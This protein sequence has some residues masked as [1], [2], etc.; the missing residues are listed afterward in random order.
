MITLPKANPCPDRPRGQWFRYPR[1]QGAALI[2][3]LGILALLI[4]LVVSY[5]SLATTESRS[6]RGYADGQTVKRLADSAT[7]IVMSQLREATEGFSKDGAGNLDPSSPL[8]WATQ[9]GMAHT[10]HSSGSPDRAFKL[11]SSDEMIVDRASATPL[12]EASTMANWENQ[13]GVFTD[14]NSPVMVPG[15]GGNFTPQSPI[16]DVDGLVDGASLNPPV[17]GFTYA[18][19]GVT[20]DIEGF[21]IIPPASY[22]PGEPISPINNPAPM[23]VR[24]LYVL[25][26]GQLTAPRHDSGEGTA[27]FDL[28]GQVSPTAENPIVARI[29]FW[30]DDECAKVNVNTAS[31]GTYWDIPRIWS[32]E[33]IGDYVGDDVLRTPGLSF[34]QPAQKE[35]QRYAG[36]PATTSL[37]PVLGRILPRPATINSS[38]A[39]QFEDYY[40]LT[41]RTNVGG[42]RSGTQIVRSPIPIKSDRLFPSVSDFL[43][44]PTHSTGER[45]IN[46]ALNADLV[47]RAGF[48]LSAHSKAPET[49]LFNT[50]RIAIWPVW[51]DATKRTAYD[52]L[53]AFCSTVGGQPFHF[54]RSDSRSGTAGLTQRNKDLYTWIFNQTANEIPGYGGNFAAKLGE[55]RQ[56]VLTYI[57]DYIRSTNPQDRS[58][59]ATPFTPIYNSVNQATPGSGEIIPIRIG[60]TQGFGRYPA[61]SSPGIMFVGAPPDPDK[62]EVKRMEAVFVAEFATPGHGMACMRSKMKWRVRGLDNLRIK[63]GDSGSESL[64]LPPDG[65]CLFEQG[66]LDHWGG[67]GIGGTLSVLAT[68]RT[69]GRGKKGLNVWGADPG[70]PLNAI[71]LN[72]PFFSEEP[73]AI[74]EPDSDGEPKNFE[75]EGGH[76]ITLDLLSDTD[77]V[78]QTSTFVFPDGEFKIPTFVQDFRQRDM[79]WINRAMRNQDTIVGLEPAGVAGNE[80]NAEPDPTAGDKRLIAGLHQVP[81]SRFRVHR[82]YVTEGVQ[83][84]HSFTLTTGPNLIPSNRS[85]KLI[86]VPTYHSLNYNRTPDVPPSPHFSYPALVGAWL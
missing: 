1:Q 16:I 56:Q 55:D 69:N 85:G 82:D 68:F 80:P 33:D 57:Y 37:S 67:R 2:I 49:T 41:P 17:S 75:F 39:G 24:W 26:D 53:A 42:S 23:P 11:Y 3:T 70:D 61:L 59:G 31:E 27:V 46:G 19:D 54:T 76:E 25:E 15:T 44:A 78:V 22:R 14:L 72:Y 38:T 50:P 83:H 36:H 84:A 65:A 4:L 34:G 29:A 81:A 62:P 21:S 12:D 43:F 63:F 35:F 28:P 48:F 5:L 40:E 60:D 7:H 64:R 66:D 18:S 58:T 32:V 52:R 13:S 86:N 73:V 8:A 20:P 51:E 30:S 74:P 45:D 79:W 6:T 10:F 71:P 9:P 77:E 47:R